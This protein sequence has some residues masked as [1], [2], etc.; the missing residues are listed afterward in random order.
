MLQN[1]LSLLHNEASS[2]PKPE[3]YRCLFTNELFSPLISK[4]ILDRLIRLFMLFEAL[5]VIL[6]PSLFF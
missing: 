3:V 2:E 1:M 5:I 4:V 6:G